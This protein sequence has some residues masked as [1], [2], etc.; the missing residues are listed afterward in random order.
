MCLTATTCIYTGILPYFLERSLA[1]LKWMLSDPVS[2]KAF[3]IAELDGTLNSKGEVSR[4][5]FSGVA[6][7]H[8]L[9]SACN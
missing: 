8:S 6:V 7:V 4:R 2:Q 3:C 1:S 5:L 9:Y